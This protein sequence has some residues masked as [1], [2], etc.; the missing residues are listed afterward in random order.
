MASDAPRISAKGA[1]DIFEPLRFLSDTHYPPLAGICK[2]AGTSSYGLGIALARS[3][4]VCGVW[5]GFGTLVF[6]GG[7]HGVRGMGNLH[8]LGILIALVALLVAWVKESSEPGEKGF[9]TESSL[10]DCC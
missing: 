5:P 6:R 3:Y 8:E 4:A 2:R 1:Y 7:S 9:F 10:W